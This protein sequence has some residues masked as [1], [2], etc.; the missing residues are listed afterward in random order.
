[1]TFWL[2]QLIHGADPAVIDGAEVGA[3]VTEAKVAVLVTGTRRMTI[4]CVEVVA[5]LVGPVAGW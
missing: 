5:P 1:M 4:S 3:T 2:V